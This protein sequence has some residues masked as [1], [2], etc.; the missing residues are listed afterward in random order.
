MHPRI[1]SIRNTGV[2]Q[3]VVAT[4]CFLLCT[5]FGFK[6]RAE[7]DS[8]PM[9]KQEFRGAWVATVHNIN[10]PSR[11]GATAVTQKREL[12]SILDNAVQ[13]RLNAI[14]FQVRPACDALYESI[15][16]SI[17]EDAG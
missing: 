15:L 12:I 6:S 9:P 2:K 14:I 11:P 7:N 1:E 4:A 10:W 16:N 17:V 8:P 5:I 3:A 13:N